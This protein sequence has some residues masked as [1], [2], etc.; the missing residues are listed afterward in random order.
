MKIYNTQNVRNVVLLGSSKSGKTTLAETM[1][2]E[3]KV[4]DR[5]GSI[6]A[7]NTISDNTE[8]EQ[9]YQ[10]SIYSTLLYT[11]FL[12][13]KFNIIDTP[14]SDDFVGGVY[15]AFS[16]AETGIMLVNATQGVEVGT[17]IMARHAEKHQKPL[18]VAVN[19]LD[20]EKQDWHMAVDS[21]KQ[22]FGNKIVQIQFPVNPGSGF[23]SFIDVLKMKMYRFKDENG[24]RE[25]LEIPEQYADEAAELHQQLLEM[26]AEND[27][28]LMETFFDKGVL[29]ED[30]IRTG[31]KV[32]MPKGDI[33]PVFCL[34]AKKDI[35]VKRLM[36][37]VINVA[38]SP[39][40]EENTLKNGEKVKVDPNGPTSIFVYK[41]ALE[42][43][44]GDVTYFKV[45]SGKLTEGMD[46]VNP[47]TGSKERISTIYAAAGKK[48]EKISE[49]MAG[50][51]ACTVKLKSVKTGQTLN[52]GNCDWVFAPIKFPASKYRTAIKAKD[53]KD[54]EKL[55]EIL[56]R[57][58]AED[59]TIV[60]EYSKE[61]KQTIL[62]GQ[63]EHHI[64]ILKW[65]INNVHKMEVELF[66][67]KI[68]YRETITKVARADYR[69]KK[70]SGGAGQFGEVHMLIEP[71]VEGMSQNNRFKVDGMELVLNIKGKEEY[72]LEWGGKLEYY[73]CIVGGS[74]DARFMPAILKGVMEKMD[75]GPLTGSYARD[76]RVYVYDGKMHP[77]DSNELSFKLAARNA[78]KEAFKKAGPKIMEPIYN[79]EV[80]VPSDCMGDVMSDLQNRRAMIEG[81]SSEKGFEVIK[82][83]VPLA[84]LYKYST[85]LS[86]LTSGRATFTMQFAEYQQ[87][88]A[89]VQEKLL[90]AYEAQE[91]DE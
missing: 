14:G 26:A 61:L 12:D 77:V 41:T 43:H 64:N 33:M 55:G 37:F 24:T 74:I 75:E 50:D 76:I 21:L 48:R 45:M 32:G 59:P 81:M 79:V 90:K 52:A 47:E 70:Q 69:H 2:F 65:Q 72:N 87:V 1:M 83:R 15:S 80:W 82:A 23:D 73:N 25:E 91:K 51:I 17:E 66:A 29:T 63:G 10:R 28:A 30:E 85:T 62:S 39:D 20:H 71:Y 89:D 19:Q 3:G 31:L 13:N 7:K 22:A 78:F 6:E 36:E 49:V 35:G 84:E 57:A 60:V 54:D 11:E 86:S 4:I 53:E 46:L 67:P 18:I 38:P 5:R 44:L 34:S 68:P 40:R 8:I 42:Q 16:V 88:P 56:Q 27:E 58:S 9:I